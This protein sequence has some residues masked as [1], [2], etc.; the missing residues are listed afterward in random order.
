MLRLVASSAWVLLV[1]GGCGDGDDA[2]PG[3]APV[4]PCVP[5]LATAWSPSWHPPRAP[6]PGACTKAQI[7]AQ[8]TSCHSA[9]GSQ[10]AC[11]ALRDDPANQACNSCIYTDEKEATYGPII[12]SPNG[13]WRT[14][15]PGCIA[16]LDRDVTAEGCAAR[17]QASSACAET[18][19]S[20][21]EP[22]EK[23]L[24]CR[25][26]AY[27]TTCRTPYFESICFLR[28]DY[29]TCVD[30]DTNEEYFRSVVNLFCVA[31]A[32]TTLVDSEGDGQ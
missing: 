31:A 11:R 26:S 29:T 22:Y 1:F 4:D 16:L 9:S 12:W 6:R 27:T 15:T 18:A 2:P 28:P 20:A 32:P 24:E 21:C 17:V 7:D 13:S 10:T 8:Y 3:S 19:C 14:N 5:H 23:Y 30:Y 25:R